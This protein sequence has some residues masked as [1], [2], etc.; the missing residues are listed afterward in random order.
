VESKCLIAAGAVVLENTRCE[1]GYIYA[2]VPARK[3]KALSQEFMEDSVGRIAKAYLKYS[4]WF[5]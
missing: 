1:S 2:G 4:G 5:K 3:V